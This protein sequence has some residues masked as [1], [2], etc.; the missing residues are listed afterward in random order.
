MK[1]KYLSYALEMLEKLVNT[2]SPSGFPH[3]AAGLLM[4]E[5][6]ALG[7]RP[8]RTNKGGVRVELGGPEGEALL[9]CSHVDTLGGI[10][11]EVKEDGRLKL[12]PVGLLSPNNAEA[13]NVQIHTRDGRVYEGTFQL[14]DPSWHVNPQY[15]AT[16][17]T[18]DV[19]EAVVDERTDSAA[20]TRAL[21]IEVG[22]F[23][24][25]EPRFRITDS[26]YIKSRHLD[27]KLS[28]SILLAYARY[29]KEENIRPGRK[30]YLHFTVYEE[31]GH[32]ASAYCPKD[33]TDVLAVDMGCVGKGISCT[34]HTVSICAKD[35]RGPSS[36]EMVTG[37]VAAAK[38]NGVAYAIDVYPFYG[39]DAD[40]VLSAGFD[41]RHAVI[42]AGVAASH[43]Y[44]RSHTD[45]LAA[46]FDL[47]AAYVGGE[48][49]EV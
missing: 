46:T 18:F 23:V 10:V 38:K 13:E 29:L 19:M 34:E 37:L 32:G 28:A 35:S 21:G 49:E 33:V 4:E 3:L 31:I 2:P 9:M 25:F 27:D 7:Y 11:A 43:G 5:L 39:S 36:Y 47:I 17:R 42:G 48:P 41:V 30:V 1:K 40:A 12:S 24:S 16:A 20:A 44:E 15:E 45:G 14:V 26:G 22:D 6:T 8:V